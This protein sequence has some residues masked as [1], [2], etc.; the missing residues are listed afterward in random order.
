MA[1]GQLISSQPIVA[2][3]VAGILFALGRLIIRHVTEAERDPWLAK[4]LTVCL[5]LHL[6]SAPLQIWVVNHLYG[7]VA[8]YNGYDT[9]GALLATG[10]RHLDFSLTQAN[11]GGIVANGSVSIV[12]AVVFTFVGPDQAAAFLIFSWLSFVGIVFFYRAF[13]LTFRGA[14]TH[15]YGYLVFFLPGL[16]FWTSD[17]SKEAIMTFLLGL[18]AY[19]CACILAHSGPR[20]LRS[21]LLIGA[22][23]VG[24]V[25]I[26]PNETL[27]ALGGFMIA[28]LFRP[29]QNRFEPA[30]RT[31]SLVLLAAALGGAV[32]VT[33]NFLPGAHGS[34]SL[35]TISS[36]NS[37]AG[38]GFGSSGVT[39][40]ANLIDYP[41]DVFVVLFDPLPFNAHGG[42]EWLEAVE[43]FVLV[44][45][46]L[47]SLRR[48]RILPRAMFARP[49]L[50]MCLVFTGSFAYAFAALGNL[51]LITREAT[52]VL[53]FFLAL[54]CIP[55]GPRHRP[56]RYL[57]ELRRRD[58]AAAR[59]A[60]ERPGR[61]GAPRRPVRA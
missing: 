22:C 33:L 48:I 37:G 3:F 35:G 49:Y 40:S 44:V 26:R 31:F 38:A 21:W 46:V 60:M 54:L 34:L 15:R 43:N 19:S 13:A 11:I 23:S 18:T 28:M 4:A 16:L 5:L 58:R 52:V 36:N 1:N 25:F 50:I 9:K 59:R 17:V 12:A 30:R 27:L 61:P 51:G 29:A 7:G 14:D 2:L 53:P 20:A 47:A 32:F 56:P 57:W 8:D 41:K 55:R 24:G 42:G 39:Y 10:F 45:V 6:V